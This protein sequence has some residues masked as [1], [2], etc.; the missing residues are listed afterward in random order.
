MRYE[1][2]PEAF[3]EYEEAVR[4]Y[5]GCQEGVELRFISGEFWKRT[6]G[7]ASPV[8]FL[9]LCSIPSRWI[10]CLSSQSCTITVNLDTG[11]TAFPDTPN[12]DAQRER[13]QI[14]SFAFE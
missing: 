1:F 7:A 9:T 8:F 4:Y 14:L 5:V 3:I 12:R 11:D 13:H 6:F 10:T 2:H